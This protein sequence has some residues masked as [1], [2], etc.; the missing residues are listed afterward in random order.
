MKG[1]PGC[2]LP[3]TPGPTAPD[4]RFRCERTHRGDRVHRTLE[5]TRGA[6]PRRGLGRGEASDGEATDGAA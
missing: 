4:P 2:F 6:K 1:D 5:S 3:E